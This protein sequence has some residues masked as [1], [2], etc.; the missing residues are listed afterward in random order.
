MIPRLPALA[1]FVFTAA[2]ATYT[3]GVDNTPGQK[4]MYSDPGR[5]GAV[6]GVGFESQ[7]L[8]S[9]TDEILRDMLANIPPDILAAAP[10]VILD[11]EYFTNEGTSRV[12]LNLITDRLRVSLNRAAAGRLTF[13]A[14]HLERMGQEEDARSGE[15]RPWMKPDFRLGGRIATQDAVNART[16]MTSRFHQISFELIDLRS[17]GIVWSGMYEFRKDAQDNV[18]YY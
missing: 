11:S 5:V 16:A 1:L 7:D 8:V 12:N 18:V 13:V 10:R 2:C 6:A 17:G 4:S 3:T 14:R 15:T 9:M